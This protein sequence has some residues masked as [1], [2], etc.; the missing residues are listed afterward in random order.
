MPSSPEPRQSLRSWPVEALPGLP[1]ALRQKF[2]H[3]GILTTADLIRQGRSPKSRLALAEQLNSHPQHIN[4]WTA[5]ARLA[6]LPSVGPT[7]CGLLLHAGVSSPEQLATAQVQRLHQQLQRLH[8][9]LLSQVKNCPG[10]PLISQWIQEARQ[11]SIASRGTK[12]SP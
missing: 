7:Y 9:R 3:V 10:P 8:L 5:L 1:D 4:K 2:Q 11:W 12:T 6:A